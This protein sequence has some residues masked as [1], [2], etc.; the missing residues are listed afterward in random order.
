LRYAL[1]GSGLAGV[2][3]HDS[4]AISWLEMVMGI[5][6]TH[7]YL[8]VCGDMY[9]HIWT[10][11]DPDHDFPIHLSLYH[12]ALRLHILARMTG[13][14]LPIALRRHSERSSNKK[15]QPISSVRGPLSCPLFPADC[16]NCVDRNMGRFL[17]CCLA[18]YWVTYFPGALPQVRSCATRASLLLE[19]CV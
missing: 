17:T 16:L 8:L 19:L 18:L 15:R 5:F 2:A 1:G 4:D 9:I 13:P 7:L 10:L 14:S 11:R 3:N 12:T 6:S